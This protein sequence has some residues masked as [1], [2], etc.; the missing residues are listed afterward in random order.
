MRPTSFITGR[1]KRVHA[2]RH[3]IAV[4][5]VLG[6]LTIT[7]A[8]SYALLRTQST[9]NLIAR[10]GTRQLDARLAAE[11]GISAALSKMH[12]DS[13]PGVTSQLQANVD[14]NTKYLVEYSTGDNLLTSTDPLSAEFPFRV[15]I[16]S[17]GTATDPQ[18][19]TLQTTYRLQ[20]VVQLVRRA[21]RSSNPTSW[22]NYLQPTVYQWSSSDAHLNFPMRIEGTTTF[23]GRLRLCTNYPATIATRDRYLTDLN[24]LRLASGTDN[25][26]LSG[27]VT[28]GTTSQYADVINS[29]AGGLGVGVGY[30]AASTAAPLTRPGSVTTYQL[31]P[32]GKDYSI[33]SINAT[34]GSSPSNLSLAA[35][36]VTNPL[37]VFRS[38]GQITLGSNVSLSGVLLSGDAS[39]DVQISGN[40][41]SITGRN[42]PA[43]EGTST[44][45]QLPTIISGDDFRVINNANVTVRGLTIVWDE[46]EL[47]YAGE[48]QTFDFTGRLLTAKFLGRGR[49]NWDLSDTWWDLERLGYQLQSTV[50]G[51]PEWMRLRQ[52]FDY[53]SPKL[54]LKPN[55]D[56]VQY[57]WHDWSQSIYVKGASDTGLKWN[58]IRVTPL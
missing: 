32:G 1:S 21:L 38:E 7:L 36:P 46:F 35:D 37:G 56:G 41:V 8:L 33:P 25:R 49:D 34:Y 43:L 42:L 53:R 48:G 31:Y 29:L 51:F 26:L 45:Y 10:N 57:R 39:A 19:P 27:N 12:E 54:L 11:A 40:N 15:T 14:A 52:G 28:L 47:A 22:S 55:T 50:V 44:N 24:L 4:V 2:Q 16:T 23:L 6:L 20:A 30:S 13:W 9:A 5:V 18:Q 58:L 17:T 3:G